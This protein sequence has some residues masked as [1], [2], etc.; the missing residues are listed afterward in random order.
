MSSGHNYMNYFRRGRLNEGSTAIKLGNSSR[1]I[2]SFVFL[3]AVEMI[4]Y[5]KYQTRVSLTFL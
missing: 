1:S 2:V 3:L 5:V 4:L